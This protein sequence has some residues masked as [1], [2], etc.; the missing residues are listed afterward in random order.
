MN[1]P[2]VLKELPTPL[3]LLSAFAMSQGCGVEEDDMLPPVNIED[4]NV[5][6]TIGAGVQAMVTNLGNGEVEISGDTVRVIIHSVVTKCRMKST[7][8]PGVDISCQTA[9]SDMDLDGDLLEGPLG[10]PLG[11]RIV[12]VSFDTGNL[13]GRAMVETFAPGGDVTDFAGIEIGADG[14]LVGEIKEGS[15]V[16]HEK[17]PFIETPVQPHDGGNLRATRIVA[18]AAKDLEEAINGARARA[19]ISN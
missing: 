19:D 15:V 6:G 8:E 11:G 7:T 9:A 14:V 3:L 13:T 12:E 10:G 4:T 18:G 17:L 2:K 16:N 1:S 5:A